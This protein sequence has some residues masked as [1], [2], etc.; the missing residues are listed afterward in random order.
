[1]DFLQELVARAGDDATVKFSVQCSKVGMS[2]DE[3]AVRC[4]SGMAAIELSPVKSYQE[5]RSQLAGIVAT[6]ELS[7]IRL[8]CLSLQMPKFLL[9][10]SRSGREQ[11]DALA[12]RA[13]AGRR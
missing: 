4:A 11:Q 9:R 5:L 6:I 8:S 1:M 12:N 7:S 13:G 10:K 3:E 2:S